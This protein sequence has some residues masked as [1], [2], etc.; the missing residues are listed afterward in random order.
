MKRWFYTLFIFFSVL[1]CTTSSRNTDAVESPQ[2]SPIAWMDFSS[3]AFNKAEQENKF[4]FLDLQANWCHWCHVMDDS[5]FTDTA[6]INYLNKYYVSTHADQD[7]RPDLANR[8][9]E[10]GWPAIIFLAPDGTEIVKRAGYIGPKNFLR[11]LK[12]IVKDPSPEEENS[13]VWAGDA[14][15]EGEVSK[16]LKQRL[17]NTLDTAVGGFDQGQKYVE[18]DTYEYAINHLNEFPEFPVWVKRSIEGSYNLSDTIWGGVYQYSTHY[19]WQHQHFEKLLTIQ[20]RYITMYTWYYQKFKDKKALDLAVLTANYVTEFLSKSAGE[21]YNSQDADVIPGQ[22]SAEFF[23]LS[24]QERRTKGIPRID[25]QVYASN[26]VRYAESLIYLWSV[27]DDSKYMNEAKQILK[28]VIKQKASSGVI[29][30]DNTSDIVYFEDQLYVARALSLL[31]KVDGST[32]WR[33]ELQQIIIDAS[34]VFGMPNGLYQSYVGENGLTPKPIVTE[35][36][37]WARLLNLASYLTHTP[38]YKS[39]AEKIANTYSNTQFLEEI[40]SE[41]AYLMLLEEL[42]THPLHA[43]FVK[44]EDGIKERLSK[45]IIAHHNTYLVVDHMGK[46]LKEQIDLTQFENTLFFCTDTYCSSPI[47]TGEQLSEFM[48]RL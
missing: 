25:K 32:F 38:T 14:I 22:H 31:I 17:L 35:N 33:D 27:T 30:H 9:R 4:V 48:K 23:S 1:S 44:M 21:K 29:L 46:T 20:A 26:N 24:D 15:E 39:W 11:L 41:P 18:F 40:Y 7:Q 19:D 3:E 47:T 43:A 10:Y 5:T 2:E 45:I 16:T 42:N 6:V 28:Q 12:A 13:S 37:R 36:L 34:K 8:Y